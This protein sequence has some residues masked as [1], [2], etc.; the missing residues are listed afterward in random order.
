MTPNGPLQLYVLNGSR[1]SAEYREIYNEAYRHWKEIWVSTFKDLDGTDHIVSDNFTRQNEVLAV[2]SGVR[3]VA[4]VCHR[5]VDP[6]LLSTLDDSYFQ[7]WPSENICRLFSKVS[8]VYIGNQISVESDFRKING[9]ESMKDLL[10]WLS[11]RRLHD[12]KAELVLGAVRVD[13][14]LDALFTSYGATVIQT[15]EQH[16]VQVAL[17]Y[18]QTLEKPQDSTDFQ[19]KNRLYLGLK[20][21]QISVQEAEH[22]SLKKVA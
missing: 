9:T 19:W 10:L 3:C 16:N 8:K 20:E 6:G 17:V 1:C 22:R 11:L 12:Q 5:Q 13:K 2:F 15:T 18:F 14:S 7:Q 4:M 21:D